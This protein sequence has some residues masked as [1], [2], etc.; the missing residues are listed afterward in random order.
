MHPS[1]LCCVSPLIP[2]WFESVLRGD[3]SLSPF[4]QEMKLNP[5]KCCSTFN[6]GFKGVISRVLFFCSSALICYSHCSPGRL[7]SAFLLQENSQTWIQH[8]LLGVSCK[9][10]RPPGRVRKRMLTSN[11]GIQTRIKCE[12][13][14]A[15]PLQR[16][17][18]VT[19]MNREL[20]YLED[21]Q[22]KKKSKCLWV[23]GVYD[24]WGIWF[25]ST[26]H[27]H[28][29]LNLICLLVLS[30]T[31]VCYRL[32]NS[33]KVPKMHCKWFPNHRTRYFSIFALTKNHLPSGGIHRPTFKLWL[34]PL[35]YKRCRQSLCLKWEHKKWSKEQKGLRYYKWAAAED[36]N[37]RECLAKSMR[38]L[39]RAESNINIFSMCA[40]SSLTCS[41]VLLLPCDGFEEGF[42]NLLLLLA[43]RLNSPSKE[44]WNQEKKKGS[45]W[46]WWTLAQ[47]LWHLAEVAETRS[48]RAMQRLCGTELSLSVWGKI[49][50]GWTH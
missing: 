42:E 38:P 49:G 3:E 6:F 19:N 4:E 14:H 37:E 25:F 17:N 40:Q 34:W 5:E 26:P 23:W 22:I 15:L 20:G 47:P 35:I 33:V 41:G 2:W 8:T 32:Q 39:E 13:N 44:H 1:L 30:Y 21:F 43:G 48:P 7:L 29:A 46:G 28:P 50:Q 18:L 11:L 12:F 31:W 16:S 24:S 36:G 9:R 45:H 27:N 10:L